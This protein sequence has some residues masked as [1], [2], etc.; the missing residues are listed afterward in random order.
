VDVGSSG[1]FTNERDYLHGGLPSYY[2]HIAALYEREKHYSFVA[3]FARLSLQFTKLNDRDHDLRSDMQNRLFTAS[4]YTCRFETAYSILMQFTNQTL[5]DTAL[6]TLITKMSEQSFVSEL[7]Q[8]PF[9]GL[10]DQVDE[11]LAQ[12]CSGIVDVL[13]GVPY[14]KILY[15]W[16]IK[17][18]DFRGAAAISLSRLQRLIIAGNGDKPIIEDGSETPVTQQYVN[19]INVL[20]C[21]DSDQAWILNEAPLQKGRASK[22]ADQPKR[23]VVTLNDIRKEYQAE[24]DRIAAIANNQFAFGDGDEMDVL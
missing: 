7:V 15:A 18:N 3:D 23:R 21:V 5:Q 10:H 20:S 14:H 1:Y 6:R 9:V 11:F 17:H 12:K 22:N 24:L 2:S 4:I 16:R 13:A 19:L 8:L